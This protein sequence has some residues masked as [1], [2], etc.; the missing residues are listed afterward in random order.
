MWLLLTG[1]SDAANEYT[2]KIKS[3]FLKYY[4]LAA[5]TAN[6]YLKDM[7][8]AEEIAAAVFERMINSPES[9]FDHCP[10]EDHLKSFIVTASRNLAK[11]TLKHDDIIV[12]D[13]LD[14]DSNYFDIADKAA[15][16]EG[17]IEFKMV[18]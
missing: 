4:S 3:A 15:P 2:D 16:D 8:R 14:D 7:Q 18:F 1:P 10:T 5:N 9:F 12:L 11:D 6:F 17:S 13:Y